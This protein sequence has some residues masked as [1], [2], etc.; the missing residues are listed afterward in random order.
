MKNPLILHENGDV[1]VFENS[2]FL[3]NYIEPIDVENN[4]YE[5]FDATGEVLKLALVEDDRGQSRISIESSGEIK[6]E[7]LKNILQLFFS[8]VQNVYVPKGNSVEE[9]VNE[10]VRKFGCTV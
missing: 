7:E 6:P 5:A 3:I 1:S 2:S 9:I 4:I 10:F 8:S